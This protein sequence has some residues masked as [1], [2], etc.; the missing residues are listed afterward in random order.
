MENLE[1]SIYI[2]FLVTILKK[3]K[4]TGSSHVL[5]LA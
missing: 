4:L 3:D 5:A 2:L 1:K